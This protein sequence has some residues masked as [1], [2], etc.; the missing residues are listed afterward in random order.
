M[1]FEWLATAARC[2]DGARYRRNEDV[3]LSCSSWLV[4]LHTLVSENRW[5][6]ATWILFLA[7][8]TYYSG[9][10]ALLLPTVRAYRARVVSYLSYATFFLFFFFFFLAGRWSVGVSS[11]LSYWWSALFG[12]W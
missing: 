7:T 2:E 6:L 4:I 5:Y 9:L 11:P 3:L 10:R 1:N 12:C 8:A